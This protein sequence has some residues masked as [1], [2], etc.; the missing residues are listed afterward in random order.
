MASGGGLQETFKSFATK[1]DGKEQTTADFTKWCKD[2]GGIIGK[3]CNS[4]HIDISFSKAKAKGSKNITFGELDALITE[5]AKQYKTDHKMDDAKAK[6]EIKDKLSR[7]QSKAHGATKAV[8]VG[9]VDRLTD[10][11]KYTGSHK[12]RFDEEGKGKGK[13]GREYTADNTGYVG[14]YKGAGSFEKK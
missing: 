1:A 4:N 9:G 7:A 3:N 8:K 12:E 14:A 13:D 2:A 10:T 5:M 11:N 6:E